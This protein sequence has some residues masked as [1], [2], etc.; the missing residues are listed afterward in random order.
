MVHGY[1][2]PPIFR[3]KNLQSKEARQVTRSCVGGQEKSPSYD[4]SG[5][6][7][8]RLSLPFLPQLS[9]PPLTIWRSCSST[10]PSGAVTSPALSSHLPRE[11]ASQNFM[12]FRW[13]R[14]G[15]LALCHLFWLFSGGS[16]CF[17]LKKGWNLLII[18][19]QATS[20]SQAPRLHLTYHVSWKS[21]TD[22]SL[23]IHF[24][25][26]PFIDSCWGENR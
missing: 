16:C 3:G 15:W 23:P 20:S 17:Y 21:L 8:S 6:R 22:H 19:W 13:K 4:A 24:L 10:A 25:F 14:Q 9:I 11:N 7:E 5:R 2:S 18:T 26:L 1:G 12:S